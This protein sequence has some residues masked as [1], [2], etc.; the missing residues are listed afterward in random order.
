MTAAFNM[1]DTVQVAARTAWA[2]NR[3]GGEQ[4]MQSV[5]NTFANRAKPGRWWGSTILEVCLF[6]EQYSCW[7]VNSDPKSNYQAMLAVT[8]DD[9]E[10]KIALALAGQL[11]MGSLTDITK[12]SDSYYAIRAYKP[13]TDQEPPSWSTAP[14]T[15]FK[16]VIQGQKFYTTI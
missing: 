9:A 15:K 4:G 13:F 16:L 1:G 7:I 3:S 12:G 8:Y 10:F 5:M 2:E 14:T 6:P 11:V